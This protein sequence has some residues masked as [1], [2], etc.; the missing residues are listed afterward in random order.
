MI[1]VEVFSENAEKVF[2]QGRSRDDEEH[3]EGAIKRSKRLQV[4]TQVKRQGDENQ[5]EIQEIKE[6]VSRTNTK[7]EQSQGDEGESS[8]GGA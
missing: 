7:E 3:Y 4:T 2:Y 5:K 8:S 1:F 6:K